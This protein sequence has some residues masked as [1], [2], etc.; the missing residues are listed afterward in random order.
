MLYAVAVFY[1]LNTVLGLGLRIFRSEVIHEQRRYWAQTLNNHS[2]SKW[3]GRFPSQLPQPFFFLPHYTLKVLDK[4]V[5]I[6][7]LR[8]CLDVTI[9]LRNKQKFAITNFLSK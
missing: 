1:S 7:D 3:K 5:T 6:C 4:V 9:V 8:P 2:T